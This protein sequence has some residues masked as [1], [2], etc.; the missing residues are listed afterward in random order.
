MVYK[1]LENGRVKGISLPVGDRQQI[2]AQYADDTSFT[3]LG[4]EE[5]VRNLIYTL[6]TF[7]L[8]SGLVLNW[9]KSSGHWKSSNDICRPVW[10]YLLGITWAE[11]DSVSKLLGA[12]FGLSLTS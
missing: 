3:L 2:L 5:P 9:Q 1:E 7:C 12:P 11:E 10:T 4:E 8:A 6:E